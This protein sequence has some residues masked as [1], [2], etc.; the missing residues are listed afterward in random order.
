MTVSVNYF[1]SFYLKYVSYISQLM[2]IIYFEFFLVSAGM[3]K[4]TR[5]CHDFFFVDR[6]FEPSEVYWQK[7]IKA[8]DGGEELKYQKRIFAFPERLLLPKGK[9]EGMPFQF[10]IHVAPIKGEP[11]NYSSRIFGD[12][13]MDNRAFGYPLDRPIQEFD[14][15][16]SNFFFKD[17]LIYHQ[18]E[19]D[20]TVMF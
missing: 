1:F 6:E 13:L 20:H 19:H 10:F 15:H 7:I 11:I 17:V 5:N 12:S 4:I 3:N 14:F 18:S 9:P 16:G 8:I 2:E